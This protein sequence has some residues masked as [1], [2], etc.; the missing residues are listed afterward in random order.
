MTIANK[1]TPAELRTLYVDLNL[2]QV[3]IAAKYGTYQNTVKHWLRAHGIS[4]GGTTRNAGDP[5]RVRWL[6]ATEATA[7]TLDCDALEPDTLTVTPAGTRPSNAELRRLHVDE[8]LSHAQIGAHFGVATSTAKSWCRRAGLVG[9]RKAAR[10]G[11]LA[12]FVEE[13]KARVEAPPPAGRPLR[14]VDDLP[15]AIQNKARAALT[16]FVAYAQAR[17]LKREFSQH[18]EEELL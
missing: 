6:D 16:G 18:E 10:A 4:K 2:T 1:P 15:V 7:T 11:A 13:A 9:A 5:K 3:E 12:R 8:G 14:K 17:R